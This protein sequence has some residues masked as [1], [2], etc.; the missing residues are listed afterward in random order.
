[1]KAVQQ[2]LLNP[3]DISLLQASG[4]PMEH[5]VAPGNTTGT[6]ITDEAVTDLFQGVQND[7]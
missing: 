6:L 1:M 3:G 5:G 4:E 2:F 7:A